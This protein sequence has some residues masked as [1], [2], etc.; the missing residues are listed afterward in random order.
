MHLLAAKPG[1]FNDDEG[2]IDLQQSAADIVILA[3]QDS[4]LSLLA[5]RAE[6]L[7][8]HY[9]SIRLANFVNLTKPAAFDLYAHRVLEKAKL[10]VVSLLGGKP[11]FAYGVEQL[12]QICHQTGAQ[13][14]LVPGDDQPD[15]ELFNASSVTR[16]DLLRLWRYLREGGVRNTDNF[17]RFIQQTFFEH[18]LSV[19]DKAAIVEEPRPFPRTLIFC[20][21]QQEQT[22]Q[23]WQQKSEQRRQQINEPLPTALLLFYRSHL[24]AGNTKAFAEFIQILERYGL[25]VLPVATTSLKEPECKALVDQLAER[26]DCRVI[27]NTTAFSIRSTTL[28][29]S[30]HGPG[31][32]H[33]SSQPDQLE[34]EAL[35]AV[36]APVLQVILAANSEADWLEHSQGLRARDI[37][38]NIALPEMDGRIIT[39]AISFKDAAGRSERTEYDQVSYRLQVDRAQFVAE[40]A[41]RWAELARKGNAEKRVALI[42]ANY[43]TRDGRIGNGV[44]LDTPASTIEIL[45]ALAQAGYSVENI[46]A[47]GTALV[48]ELLGNVTNDLSSLDLRPCQQSLAIEEY[49]HYFNALPAEAQ[50]AV[51]DRWGLPEQDPK[52]RSGR[53]MI[54]GIRL[55]ETF[56]GIQPA[57]GFNID[58][59]ANYHDPDLVPPHSYLAFYFWLRHCYQVDAFIHI[60]KHGNLEWL[61]GK[62]VALSNQCWPDI[63]LGPMPHLYPFI[64]NDPGEGAQAKRRSQAV[65]LDHLMPP[66]TRAESYGEL[67][68]LE[69]LV[70]EYYQA[71]GL[72]P[73]REAFLRKKIL[74]L[75]DRTQ[76]IAEL[77]LKDQETDD[78]NAVLNE[79]DAYL[80]ELK[81][82]QIRDGLH[83]YGVKPTGEQRIDT[84]VALT[85]LPR[86]EQ[87]VQD[88]SILE[89]LV[90]D[91][92][93]TLDEDNQQKLF[94]PLKFEASRPWNGPRPAILENIDNS[95]WRTHADT[96]ERLEL[97]AKHLVTHYFSQDETLAQTTDDLRELEPVPPIERMHS[98][99]R[100]IGAL[101]DIDVGLKPNLLLH[102]EQLFK[103]IETVII[104]AFDGSAP[105]ELR[106]L[107]NGL[108]GGFVPPGAS[109][110]PTRG[111][112]DVLPTGRNFYSVDSRSIPTPAAWELGQAS[113]EQLVLRHL[114]EHGDYPTTLGLSVWGTATMRTGG[115]DIAQAFALMGIKPIWAAGSNRVIDFEILPNFLLNRPRVD[116]TLRVSGFFRDAFPN[117]MT[118][119]DAAVSALAEHEEPGNTNTIKQRV[120]KDTALLTENGMAPEKARQQASW[121]V[122]GS[123]PGAYGA[124]LQGLIDE[125]CWDT[126]AD[127]AEA[128][129]NW[130]GY[131]YGQNNK[132]TAAFDTFEHRLGQLQAVVQNQDNREHDLLDS[133]DYYQFQGG[134]TNAV[135]VISGETPAVYHSDHS[136]PSDPKIRT[137]QEELNRVIRSRVVNP[138]W[139]N[140]MQR[141]GYKGAF[142]MAATVDYL[143]AYDATTDM[144]AD[145]QYE[146]VT[147]RYLFDDQNRA[148]LEQHN[149]KA[150]QEM[151]ERMMEA[152]QRGLWEASEEYAEKLEN[153][154]LAIEEKLEE[155]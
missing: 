151:A 107:L 98:A 26:S 14:A 100:K 112:L 36:N 84:L 30:E 120:L 73:R 144:V 35:F 88:A 64:V 44:G 38:M 78:D 109:G 59:A 48:H 127:L 10:I 4:S 82:A 97:L 9:P 105:E 58:V 150:L 133:D 86:G 24:Q 143:F 16:P 85:R 137:L 99:I 7:P 53:I 47:T 46:P 32:A 72:D 34:P 17:Y 104:P 135:R 123:K 15:E 124:G 79:L 1:G 141:H 28:A 65:V 110:A 116:V 49:Q 22:F 67:Q 121:R 52:V 41:R 23:E 71:I 60:G 56:V 102:T 130:G 93:L 140:G 12:Q 87:R 152:I 136:N 139:I 68:E 62:G 103:H 83:T 145:Y 153:L 11:Y 95:S 54:A 37:A 155:G 18:S 50:Q 114:Q 91:F 27:L 43:P 134:M 147:D 2:I 142:E 131:A 138:K 129:I 6:Q 126:A 81:E 19:A 92:E 154:L 40:L 108:N 13:L 31:N 125:R 96:R 106:Q 119:F 21:E 80:C 76:L 66:M 42:L 45:N 75:V 33:L 90:K 57:R 55:G 94:N 29:E 115:D 122:F 146:M 63:A 149:P 51:L 20:P 39:R 61:P 118:L 25:T 69:Q 117:V 111:R 3:A 5:Q 8:E 77:N 113:A 148:F 74:D 128:Y 101:F 70:D 132:G 89:C